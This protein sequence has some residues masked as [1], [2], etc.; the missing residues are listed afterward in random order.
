VEAIVLA[1][2]RGERMG[3]AALGRPKPLMRLAGRTIIAHAIE[4]L[5]E[6][7][8]N[9]VIV[10]CAAETEELF[11]NEL[12]DVEAEIVA[13]GEPEPLGRGGGLRLAAS[14]AK[15]EPVLALNGDSIVRVDVRRLL[16]FHV[17][18]GQVATV[19]VTPMPPVTRVVEV[20]EEGRVLGPFPRYQIDEWINAG[21]YV[22]GADALRRLPER[23]DHEVT[24]LPQ[25]AAERRLSAF[26]HRGI[27]LTVN[28]PDELRTAE[29]F[30]AARRGSSSMVRQRGLRAQKR[31]ND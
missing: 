9:R 13:V 27:C 2:G 5:V 11:E 18:R 23:G 1:G 6:A 16:R 30:F 26:R 3:D 21:V 8:V 29:A 14:F 25:L 22:L 31:A 24:T 10:S 20:D 28:T 17:A 7:G 4:P 12:S 19:V 15:S